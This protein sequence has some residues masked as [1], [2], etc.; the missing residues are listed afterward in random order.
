MRTFVF[1]MALGVGATAF[2]AEKEYVRPFTLVNDTTKTVV[3]LYA[4]TAK[5]DG[6]SAPGT[7][8][9]DNLKLAPGAST[10]VKLTLQRGECVYHLRAE[11]AGGGELRTYDV[12]V[13]SINATAKLSPPTAAASK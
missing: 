2:A 10:K 7:L 1:A 9:A 6:K 11:T 5:Y 13:C 12:D 3:R 4:A 8:V